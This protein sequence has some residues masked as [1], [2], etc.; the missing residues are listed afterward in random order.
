MITDGGVVCVWGEEVCG[1][2]MMG[3]THEIFLDASVGWL[4]LFV[5]GI[6]IE[7]RGL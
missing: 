4:I 1:R 5:K 2:Y 3:Q 7:E 6:W